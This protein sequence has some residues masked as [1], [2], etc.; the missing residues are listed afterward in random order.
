MAVFNPCSGCDIVQVRNLTGNTSLINNQSQFLT[1]I[2]QG[3]LLGRG[4]GQYQGANNI[5]LGLFS[6]LYRQARDG[7][8]GA[9]T[10]A[11]TGSS[12]AGLNWA[13]VGTT[14]CI[15][16]SGCSTDLRFNFVANYFL[17]SGS[18]PPLYFGVQDFYNGQL[19][20]TGVPYGQSGSITL[21][22]MSG[23]CGDIMWFG[24]SSYMVPSGVSSLSGF[25][26]GQTGFQIS[27]TPCTGA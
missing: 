8:C 15:T 9:L 24:V 1:G 26:L 19:Y 20:I 14:G 10:G 4:F 25:Y 3:F 18:T 7:R 16:A 17:P 22:G 21:T 23:S 5:N 27:C 12:P 11:V 6:V 2:N 13:Y